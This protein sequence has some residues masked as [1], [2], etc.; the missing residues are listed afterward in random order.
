[1]LSI[2]QNKIAKHENEIIPKIAALP[3]IP[4]IRLNELIM[5]IPIKNGEWETNNWSNI[6]NAQEAI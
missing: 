5:D 4:S 1:M 2:S 6:V 3:S